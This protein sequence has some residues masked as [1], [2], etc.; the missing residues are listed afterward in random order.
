[1]YSD[2]RRHDAFEVAAGCAALG[3]VPAN[4]PHLARIG[5]LGRY[6]LAQSDFRHRT[7]AH[8][9][10]RRW[11]VDAPSL[12]SGPKWDEPEGLFCEPVHF[13]GGSFTVPVAGEPGLV[14]S[15]QLVLDALT[16]EEWL[17][18]RRNTGAEC[19]R[20]PAGCFAG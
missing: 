9:R 2:L 3:L 10:W 18:R 5:A 1:L 12:H 4:V 15:L 20:S 13:F 7:P 16:F 17:M 6:V 11:L 19:S 14:F 8:D